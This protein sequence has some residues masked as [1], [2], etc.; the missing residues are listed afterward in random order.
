LLVIIQNIDIIS[1]KLKSF[2]NEY[3]V[4]AKATKKRAARFKVHDQL[5]LHSLSPSVPRGLI[6]VG[7]VLPDHSVLRGPSTREA[8]VATVHHPAGLNPKLR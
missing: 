5:L 7:V 6:R 1:K 3:I 2:Q 4:A 8:N